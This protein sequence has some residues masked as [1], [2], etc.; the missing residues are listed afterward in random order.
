MLYEFTLTA[1]VDPAKVDGILA[2]MHGLVCPVSLNDDKETCAALVA[3]AIPI[4]VCR[5]C[6]ADLH[7]DNGTW[8]D[9][10]EG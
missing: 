9:E 7:K 8:V 1:D 6:D 3:S 2:D 10:T 4:I 5:F